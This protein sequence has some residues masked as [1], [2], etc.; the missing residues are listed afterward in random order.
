LGASLCPC[1]A[2]RQAPATGF[3]EAHGPRFL[4]RTEEDAGAAAVRTQGFQQ[5]ITAF[6]KAKMDHGF[7]F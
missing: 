4:F 2:G 5:Q 7:S 6:E 1:P 3:L